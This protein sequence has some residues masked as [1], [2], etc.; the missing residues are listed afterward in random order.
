M[1][2]IQVFER[3]QKSSHGSRRGVEVS[4]KSV[5]LVGYTGY[6][7]VIQHSMRLIPRSI[8]VLYTQNPYCYFDSFREKRKC[9]VL[10]NWQTLPQ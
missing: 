5:I 6:Y 7:V 3:K 1:Q 2:L 9:F 4:L 8:V 10:P